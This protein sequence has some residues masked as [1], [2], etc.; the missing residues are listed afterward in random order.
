M[1]IRSLAVTILSMLAFGILLANSFIITSYRGSDCHGMTMGEFT[2]QTP[3]HPGCDN[4]INPG[5][6]SVFVTP[7]PGDEGGCAFPVPSVWSAEATELTIMEGSKSGLPAPK[8]RPWE[9]HSR[10]V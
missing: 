1:L 2:T 10:V 4:L 9:S 6:S 8:R 7:Q 5:A 3:G